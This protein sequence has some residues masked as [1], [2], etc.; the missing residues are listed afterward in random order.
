MT[1]F[2]TV[3]APDAA[4]EA[5]HPYDTPAIL[6]LAVTGGSARYLDWLLAESAAP[7]AKAGG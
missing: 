2:P 1:D 4:V 7:P 6:S 3:P 5:A